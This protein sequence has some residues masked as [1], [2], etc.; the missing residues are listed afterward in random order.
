[1]RLR[2]LPP[3]ALLLAACTAVHYESPRFDQLTEGHRKVAVLPFEIVLTGKTPAG[4]SSE[5]VARIEEGESVA[6]QDA[7]YNRLLNRSSVHRRRPILIDLQPVEITN[8]RLAER[9]IALRDTWTMAAP[10]L[11]AIL[12]VDALVRTRVEKAR[13][14]SDP[15]SFGVS[16]GLE[17]LYQATEGHAAALLPPG[18][19]KTHD[20]WANSLVVRGEDGELLWKVGVHR[21]TDWSRPAND[22]IFG[23]TKKLAKKFPYRG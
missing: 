23:I 14:L 10:Q 7:L 19:A 16:V 2:Y 4:L 17:V 18:L 6:F 20:I 11:A 8:R 9:G 13:Y 5:V 3:I 21:A 1:M 12:G 22:V 15:A